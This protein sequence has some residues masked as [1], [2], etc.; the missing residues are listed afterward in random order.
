MHNQWFIINIIMLTSQAK[1]SSLMAAKAPFNMVSARTAGF[2]S[3]F[4]KLDRS[5]D[6]FDASKYALP[7]TNSE[8][9]VTQPWS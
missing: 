9:L 8:L 1:W 7:K 4:R 5:L 6:Q 3:E 2:A